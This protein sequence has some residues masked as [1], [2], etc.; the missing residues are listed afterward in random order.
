MKC[1]HRIWL[2]ATIGLLLAAPVQAQ[3]SQPRAISAQDV[4]KELRAELGNFFPRAV[5]PAGGFFV[6]F[7]SDWSRQSEPSRSTVSQGRQTWITAEVARR[8]PD[9]REEFTRY[10]RHGADYLRT[11]LWDPQYGGFFWAVD[12]QNRQPRERGEK[13]LY[14]NAFGLYGLAAAYRATSDAAI[15]ES[16]QNAF[17][18]IERHGHDDQHEGY[19]EAFARDGAPLL[20]PPAERKTD[21]LGT[22]YGYKSMNAH[23]HL[24]EAYTELYR[25]W[26][27]E[28]LKA[29]IVELIR[30]VA[31]RMYV[32][33]GCLHMQYTRDWRPLPAP[34]SYGHD[35]ETTFLL[36]EAAEAIGMH[37][38]R[39]NEI[40]KNLADHSIA[41]GWD[42]DNGGL[43]FEGAAY[44]EVTDKHKEWWAQ[45][46]SANTLLLMAEKTGDRNYRAYFEKQWTFIRD[47]QIDHTH[48]GWHQAVSAT[49]EAP[50]RGS[51][52]HEWKL[53]YHN[54]RAMLNIADRLKAMSAG[55]K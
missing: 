2:A 38:A 44:G 19:F 54:C 46:E 43:F 47:F 25:A 7:G 24:L 48:G 40:G 22:L 42:K 10:T 49:G 36:D 1:R 13:H 50:K 17:N 23:I 41:Y 5:D 15:L 26:P 37:N 27:N 4:E 29:R 16:A 30:L 18:W 33:P 45:A 35:I 12:P 8:R 39:L 53:A 31:D 51:K 9:L 3:S 6:N 28:K 20:N 32:D 11:V 55:D 21:L 34:D 14:S 52:G